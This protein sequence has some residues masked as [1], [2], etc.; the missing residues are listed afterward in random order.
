MA[1]HVAYQE[2]S[3]PDEVK[4]LLSLRRFDLDVRPQMKALHGLI[5]HVR[6]EDL[7]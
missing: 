7:P 2:P 3:F 5:N 6:Q 1:S 4:V